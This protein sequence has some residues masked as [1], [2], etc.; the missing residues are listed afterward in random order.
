MCGA[1]PWSARC[2][3]GLAGVD[4][5]HACRH[6]IHHDLD[7]NPSTLEQR[8]GRVD[9]I[10]S[11]AARVGRPVVVYE[12]YVGGTHDEKMFR[13]VKDRER[14]FGIVMGESP[15]SSEWATERQAARIPLP[16][17]LASALAMD[18]ATPVG[19][20]PIAARP[21]SGQEA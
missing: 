11:Q 14:W 2:R 15:D 19:Q 7:W 6:V 13:V 18:L 10:G 4:L 17:V 5:H 8:T 3:C 12:P 21:A 9:R 1:L 20:R 16:P